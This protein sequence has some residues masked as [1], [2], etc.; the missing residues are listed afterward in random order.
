MERLNSMSQ[1]CDVLRTWSKWNHWKVYFQGLGFKVI[2]HRTQYVFYGDVD[3]RYCAKNLHDFGSQYA[4]YMTFLMTC[5]CTQ[6]HTNTF[7][8]LLHHNSL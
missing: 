1:D 7:L 4:L 8:A 2:T 5:N 3:V 6:F